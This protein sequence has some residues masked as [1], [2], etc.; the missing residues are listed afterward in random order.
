[1]SDFGF[2]QGSRQPDEGRENPRLYVTVRTVFGTTIE[3]ACNDAVG[4][5]K[6]LGLGVRFDFN[7][8]WIHAW[9]SS[10]PGTLVEEWVRNFGS[11]RKKEW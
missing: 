7:G 2:V 9:P 10:S 3:Q 6:R 4:A 8:I 1:M 11:T 5:S